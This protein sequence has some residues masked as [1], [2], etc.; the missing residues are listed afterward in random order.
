MNV[1]RLNGFTLIEILVV[2]ALLVL[3]ITMFPQGLSAL[4]E[5][6]HYQAL[7]QNTVVSVRQ[8]GLTAQQQQ[9]SVRLGSSACP[10]PEEI[11]V[12]NESMPYFNADGTTSHSAHIEI[13][14]AQGDTAVVTID[15]LTATVRVLDDARAN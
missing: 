11:Q 15:K 4:Y 6:S 14:R 13:N 8:C 5:R 7:V 10:L 9:R 2:L 3:I 1:V 12:E